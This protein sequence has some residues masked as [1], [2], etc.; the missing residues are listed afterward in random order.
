MGAYSQSDSL[1]SQL[2]NQRAASSKLSKRRSNRDPN[3]AR[4]LAERRWRAVSTE[5]ICIVGPLYVPM[6]GYGTAAV[7]RD[8]SEVKARQLQFMW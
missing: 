7:G 5:P 3:H 6:S 2:S 4:R 8:E 1:I